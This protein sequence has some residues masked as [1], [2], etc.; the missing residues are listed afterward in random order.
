MFQL[1]C[2]LLLARSKLHLAKI[3]TQPFILLCARLHQCEIYKEYTASIFKM[4]MKM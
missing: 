4:K 3:E 2:S 1:E